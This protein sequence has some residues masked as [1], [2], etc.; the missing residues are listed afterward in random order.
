MKKTGRIKVILAAIAIVALIAIV[1]AF[2]VLKAKPVKVDVTAVKVESVFQG[3]EELFRKQYGED[4]FTVQMNA[5]KEESKTDSQRQW[6]WEGE[7]PSSDPS[8][9]ACLT[10]E[11]SG[12]N[13][14]ITD[15]YREG[16]ALEKQGNSQVRVITLNPLATPVE[17]NRLSSVPID[18]VSM[19]VFVGKSSEEEL[20]SAVRD[21]ELKLAF[22]RES[23]ALFEISK[24]P[25]DIKELTFDR[26]PRE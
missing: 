18:R 4:Y 21:M 8:D 10:V 25:K 17:Y 9:Y 6:L 11:L 1:A 15:C 26:T 23:G 16:A 24:S 7:L 12:R 14:V 5:Y 13:R 20:L 19:I 2:F 3:Y 22:Q